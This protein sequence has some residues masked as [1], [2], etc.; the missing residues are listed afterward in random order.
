MNI[1]I[2]ESQLGEPVQGHGYFQ[3]PLLCV[4]GPRRTKGVLVLRWTMTSTREPSG[5]SQ[6][7]IGCPLRGP[8][9]GDSLVRVGSRHAPWRPVGPHLA[10]VP[11][12]RRRGP[13][14]RGPLRANQDP[15]HTRTSRVPFGQIVAVSAGKWPCEACT[16]STR[17]TFWCRTRRRSW[18][19]S[20]AWRDLPRCFAS[21]KTVHD[22]H[23]RWSADGTWERTC[24]P[25]G[26]AGAL[27]DRDGVLVHRARRTTS[28]R[29]SADVLLGAVH[30]VCG[31]PPRG[32]ARRLSADRAAPG[33]GSTR[34]G[35]GGGRLGG[36]WCGHDQD[37]RSGYALQ[38][39][40]LRE[41]ARPGTGVG[42]ECSGRRH[43]MTGRGVAV[44][45]ER[46]GDGRSERSRIG[47][48]RF[49]GKAGRGDAR[50]P[51]GRPLYQF[52]PPAH[53]PARA[54]QHRAAGFPPGSTGC[55]T[56]KP[57]VPGSPPSSPG[58]PR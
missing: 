57:S 33:T 19:S 3:P 8:S 56:V 36:R 53:P 20:R 13:S 47:N 28:A 45:E 29:E 30:E 17:R 39:R 4:P 44:S 55:R 27:V 58:P 48:G 26:I 10:C 38:S 25:L 1:A 9:P 11:T 12:H 32:T 43:Q 18:A 46:R 5:A 54:C 34:T 7:P 22:R 16:T 31:R 21:W 23:R 37:R 50:V 2:E 15:G 24:R 41:I 52:S 35:E 14:V 6:Q 51:P 49:S 40:T 42:A